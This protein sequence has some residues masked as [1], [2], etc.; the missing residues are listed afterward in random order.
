MM[1]LSVLI[2]ADA[3]VL[4]S[5]ILMRINRDQWLI[6]QMRSFKKI[7]GEPLNFIIEVLQLLLENINVR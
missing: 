6:W 1:C 4:I 2:Y 3:D 7:W 5:M